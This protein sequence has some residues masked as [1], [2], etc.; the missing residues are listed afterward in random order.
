MN[1]YKKKYVCKVCN[2]SFIAYISAKRI[3]CSRSCRALDQSLFFNSKFQ[4][5]MSAR[6]DNT[7]KMVP[8]FRIKCIFCNKIIFRT[9]Y[10]LDRNKFYCD[11]KCYHEHR[12]TPR[13]IVYCKV[14]N[15]KMKIKFKQK[16]K[17]CSHE[18]QMKYHGS[19]L[20]KMGGSIAIKIN[21]QHKP[22]LYWNTRFDSNAEAEMCKLLK[23][24][25]IEGKN[26]H[27]SVGSNE[28]DFKIN[29]TFIEYHPWDFN[30]TP[31]Q[32]YNYRRRILNSNGYENNK[33]IVIR[34]LQNVAQL[35]QNEKDRFEKS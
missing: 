24:R 14:C 4:K 20:G 8:R 6:V 5:E 12:I 3:Y 18:C 2:K 29:D 1:Q 7:K 25:P 23:L 30:K 31:K 19:R 13:Y 34:N 9:K 10:E 22:Y 27:V 33:L 26:V 17:F 16:K 35:I 15:K 28:F 32:Y 21:R 11:S